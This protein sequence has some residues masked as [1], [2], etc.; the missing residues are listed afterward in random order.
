MGEMIAGIILMVVCVGSGIATV[1]TYVEYRDY[2][3]WFV[4]SFLLWAGSFTA[5]LIMGPYVFD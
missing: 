1:Y 2:D 4:P 5:L 3:I